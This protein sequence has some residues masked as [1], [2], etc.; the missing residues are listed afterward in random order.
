MKFFEKVHS[1]PYDWETA[2]A[3]WW[4]KYPNPEQPHVRYWDTLHRTL[5]PDSGIL[6]VNRLFWIEYGLPKWVHTLF[7]TH[8]MDGYGTEHVVCDVDK[9]ILT[10]HGRN[11]TFRNMIEIEETCTYKQ[12]PDNPAWTQFIHRSEF[13]VA[14]LGYLSTKLEESA[15]D[16]AFGKS[17]VGVDVMERLIH[18]LHL[19]EWKN[20][21]DQWRRHLDEMS[22]EKFERGKEL[23]K[24][25]VEKGRDLIKTVE[26]EASDFYDKLASS[27]KGSDKDNKK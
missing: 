26:K 11:Y 7:R 4:D 15:R 23:I 3:A 2:T 21:A 9:K 17:K 12:H 25:E 16:S 22:H 14:K 18:S 24:K 27:S 1:Y 10:M 8:S 20:K 5:S 6:T 19:S 13:R